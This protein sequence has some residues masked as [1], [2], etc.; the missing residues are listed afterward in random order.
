M[1]SESLA[2]RK[3]MRDS[4][5]EGYRRMKYTRIISLIG[6]VFGI[7]STVAN[8]QATPVRSSI[9]S[10]SFIYLTVVD[11]SDDTIQID[12]QLG[13]IDPLGL[14]SA[15]SII[16]SSQGFYTGTVQTSAEFIDEQHGE[17]DSTMS[18]EGNI[19]SGEIQA[20][21]YG[22]TLHGIFEYEFIIPSDGVLNLTGL[23]TNPGP[24]PIQFHAVIQMSSEFVV[25]GGFTGSFFEQQIFDTEFDSEQINIQVPLTSNS[26]S[27]RLRIRLTHSGIGQLDRSL[28]GGSL[29][30]SWSIESQNPC[31]ADFTD[32]GV[33]NFFDVSAF[34]NAFSKE[35]PIADLTNDGAFNFF[36]V[37]AFLNA[38]G[39]GC[40]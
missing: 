40:L 20:Q 33:L 15:T 10:S 39:T 19:G 6:V 12:D 7:S 4:A 27:Y 22:H 25:G 18:Y 31:P 23:L 2:A 8:A 16:N 21:Q 29:S 36:D 38:F 3:A 28:I 17:F 26:G 14:I 24:S 37:S 5:Q 30:T 11:Q 34:L 32:D 1:L 9:E 35:D 13:T